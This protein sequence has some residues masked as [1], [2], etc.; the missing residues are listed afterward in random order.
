MHPENQIQFRHAIISDIPLENITIWYWRLSEE[1][2][3]DGTSEDGDGGE[4]G[5]GSTRALAVGRNARGGRDRGVLRGSVRAGARGLGGSTGADG[6]RDGVRRLGGSASADRGRDGVDRDGV[7]RLGVDGLSG[8]GGDGLRDVGVA[9]RDSGGGVGLAR[10]ALDLRSAR[11]DGLKDCQYTQSDRF[12][13]MN[14]HLDLG[15]VDGLTRD[16]ESSS[17]EEDDGGGDGRETHF[18][19][20]FGFEKKNEVL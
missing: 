5:G 8:L 20:W 2:G 16:S 3:G 9:G 19:C 12:P 4:G 6:G 10:A 17:A 14:T 13:M 7:G 18:D 1:K 15:L 11:G